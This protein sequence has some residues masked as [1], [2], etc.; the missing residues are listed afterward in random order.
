MGGQ[1]DDRDSGRLL[2]LLQL[3]RRGEAI[4]PRHGQIHQ[5]KGGSFTQGGGDRFDAVRGL[6][7]QEVPKAQPHGPEVPKSWIV[8]DN[9]HF[10]GSG[11][12]PPLAQ[13]DHHSRTVHHLTC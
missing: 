7:D 3:T 6:D 5:D 8:V 10:L 1:G 12:L 11:I 13:S 2:V 4:E 9:E